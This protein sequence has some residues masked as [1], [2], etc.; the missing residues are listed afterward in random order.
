MFRIQ[1]VEQMDPSLDPQGHCREVTTDNELPQTSRKK[2]GVQIPSG[3][4]I[5]ERLYNDQGVRIRMLRRGRP[6]RIPTVKELIDH[7][8]KKHEHLLELEAKG[9]KM[10][11]PEVSPRNYTPA[12]Y[13]LN[14][15][16][17]MRVESMRCVS[18]IY[19]SASDTARGMAEKVTE[20]DEIRCLSERPIKFEVLEPN[21]LTVSPYPKKKQLKAR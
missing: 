21:G 15:N 2:T 8:S 19:R 14:H 1:L 20:S 3:S 17:Q 5:L 4:R 18:D 12:N 16:E 13:A 11:K 7:L 9:N 6:N 10:E